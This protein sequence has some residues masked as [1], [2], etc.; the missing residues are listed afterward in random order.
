MDGKNKKQNTISLSLS[1]FVLLFRCVFV[2]RCV[3]VFRYVFV[4]RC[5]F[6][7]LDSRLFSPARDTQSPL[8]RS[9]SL[10]AFLFLITA[11]FSRSAVFSRCARTRNDAGAT[12]NRRVQRE[13]TN[14][15]AERRCR[16][17]EVARL[18]STAR[19][20]I[21]PSY[22]S[23]ATRSCTLAA[24]PAIFSSL[25]ARSRTLPPLL[26]GVSSMP[27]RGAWRRARDVILVDGGASRRRSSA[28]ENL[29]N[30]KRRPLFVT[31]RPRRTYFAIAAGEVIDFLSPSSVTRAHAH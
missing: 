29:E 28:V 3:F 8:V 27:E 13:D 23:A 24:A 2:L 11:L 7:Q 30:I 26:S 5:G 12:A 19:T 1:T 15:S 9:L 20:A 31:R 6:Y 22:T 17:V 4:F 14:W 10:S 21:R 16:T 25:S 18:V